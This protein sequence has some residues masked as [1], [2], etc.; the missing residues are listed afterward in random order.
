M[1]T[2]GKSWSTYYQVTGFT[3]RFQGTG[4][5]ASGTYNAGTDGGHSGTG[6]ADRVLQTRVL[7]KAFDDPLGIKPFKLNL[8]LQH[9][10]S[11]PRVHNKNYKTTVGVS[12]LF[13][14][15][16]DLSVGLAYNHATI[17]Q[18]DLS[19]LKSK[20]VDGDATA[21]ALGARWFSENW[22]LATVVSRLN[23]HETTNEF[24]YF[25]GMGWEVYGQYNVYKRWWAVGGWNKLDPDSSEVQAG[26]FKTDYSVLGVRYSF[27]GFR[28]FVFANARIDSGT[29]QAGKELR[30]IYTI[31]VRWD[32]P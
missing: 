15:R 24:V 22:Y 1:V 32:L 13:E 8:Q 16:D 21:L 18:A 29:N 19:V 11:I 12:A 14:T 27:R 7:I 4:A 26:E 23:N 20:G 31:G 17:D 9:G 2:A 5:S 25:D 30:N 6:R 3:D 28:Q 10:E